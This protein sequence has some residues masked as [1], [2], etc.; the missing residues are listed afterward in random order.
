MLAHHKTTVCLSLLSKDLLVCS[1][2][3]A[4]A[5]LYQKEQQRFHLIFNEHNPPQSI[6]TKLESAQ[7]ADSLPINPLRDLASQ[8]RLLWLEISPFR[9]IMTTQS[10]GNVGYRH[11]WERGVYGKSHFWLQDSQ[12]HQHYSLNLRNYTR[13]LQLEG[14]PI[15]SSLRLEYELWSANLKLGD[16]ILHLEIH[17]PMNQSLS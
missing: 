14:Y 17:Q 9:V 8:S 10:L 15:L 7:S 5:T 13:S 16:Y 1:T 4:I 6:A 3:E 2:L 11:F 12:N